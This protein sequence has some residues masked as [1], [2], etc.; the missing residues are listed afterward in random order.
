MH[1]T[2]KTTIM[3]MVVFLLVSGT[4]GFQIVHA[5]AQDQNERSV[6]KFDINKVR[7]LSADPKATSPQTDPINAGKIKKETTNIVFATLR[8]IGSL[9]LIIAL[10]FGVSWLVRKSGLAGTSRIGGGGAMDMM[11]VLPLGQHRNVV[12]FRVLDTVYLCSQT[13]SAISLLDKIEG[14]RA[15]DLLTSSKGPSTVVKFK[16]A[17]NQFVSRI[18]K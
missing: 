10:I 3:P 6:G 7:E 5:Q 12:M 8:I 16:D 11:E 4:M 17:F 1:F 18:K 13:P 9:A 15:V 14:P 2:F